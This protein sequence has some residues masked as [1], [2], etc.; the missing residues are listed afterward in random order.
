MNELMRP[1]T[2]QGRRYQQEKSVKIY[3]RQSKYKA[4][5]ARHVEKLASFVRK[6]Y[7]VVSQNA[8]SAAPRAAD[9]ALDNA[10]DRLR[11]KIP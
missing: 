6:T 2:F 9:V 10:Q 5:D 1:K 11:C 7:Q 4:L 8:A 3:V